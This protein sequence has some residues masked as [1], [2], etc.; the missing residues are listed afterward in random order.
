MED[1]IDWPKLVAGSLRRDS[2]SEREL[3]EALLPQVYARVSRL[4][5]RRSEVEDLSQEVFRKVFA[6]LEKFRGGVFPA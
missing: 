5:P 4:L 2:L 1:N 6:N 3:V